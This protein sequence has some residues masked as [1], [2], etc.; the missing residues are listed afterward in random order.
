MPCSQTE[1]AQSRKH[2]LQLRALLTEDSIKHMSKQICDTAYTVIKDSGIRCVLLYSPVRR[3]PNVLPL[4]RR[5]ISEGIDVAFPVCDIQSTRLIF[6]RVRSME[7][8]SLGAYGI[9]EPLDCCEELSPSSLKGSLCIVPALSADRQGFRLG[10]GKG[11]YDRFLPQLYERGGLSLCPLY[12]EFLC[13]HLAHE[14]TDIEVDIICTQKE[15]IYTHHE[16]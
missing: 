2:F 5:L 3:E 13:E 14:E 9:G 1:K 16:N 7:E 6:K 8:M 10:Y 15:V 4:A 11:Y 12:H